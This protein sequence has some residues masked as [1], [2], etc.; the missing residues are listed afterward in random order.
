LLLVVSGSID[1]ARADEPGVTIP[2]ELIL[3]RF[4]VN[5]G[6]DFLLVPVKFAGKKRLFAVDTGATCTAVDES[7]VSGEPKKIVTIANP[8]GVGMVKIY[9][10]PEASIGDIPLNID[11]VGALDLSLIRERSGHLIEGFLGMDFLERYVLRVDFD[12]GELFLMRSALN[13]SGEVFPL[14][15]NAQQ[16]PQMEASVSPGTNIRFLIDTGMMNYETGMIDRFTSSPLIKDGR[17]T[18]KG[19]I[20]GVDSLAAYEHM[21]L[22]GKRLSLGELSVELPVFSVSPTASSLGLTFLSRFVV[23]FDFPGRKLYLKK[24][25]GYERLDDLTRATNVSGLNLLRRDGT[26]VIDRVNP[27]SPASI[28]GFQ[29]GEVLL[30]LGATRA[31]ETSLFELRK[32]LCKPGP[33]KCSVRHGSQERSLTLNLPR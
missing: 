30:T 15:R 10:P 1:G 20:T 25:E 11:S 6:G 7:L 8:S 31:D 18:T 32:A 28:A 4:A 22:Q 24:G 3:Q 16:I 14:F 12:R 2:P 19:S 13:D 29:A 33:L 21:L 9:G 27:G 17:L 26:V 23:T 5:K